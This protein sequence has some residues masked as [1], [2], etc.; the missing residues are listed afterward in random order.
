MR[1]E[2]T[3]EFVTTLR[4]IGALLVVIGHYFNVFWMKRDVVANLINAPVLSYEIYPLPFYIDWLQKLN[5]LN[6][7]GWRV[8]LFFIISGFVIPFSLQKYT[9]T[10]FLVNRFIR[11]VPTYAIGFSLTLGM[12]WWGTYYFSTSWPYST[13]EILIHYLPGIRELADSKSIDGIIWTLEIEIKFYVLCALFIRWF[14]TYSIKIFCI[15]ILL[16]LFTL[17]VDYKPNF[18]AAIHS[19][20]YQLAMAY[21]RST[22]FI[23]FMFIG[24]LLNYLYNKKI[25][26]KNTYLG[27][28]ALFTLFCFEW[29]FGPFNA[30]FGEIKNYVF[31]LFVFILAYH[32]PSL[33]KANKF[34]TFLAN[35]SY[36]L[37]IIHG[38]CGYILL[39]ILLDLGCNSLISLAVTVSLA[40]LSAWVIH[41]YVERPMKKLKIENAVNWSYRR[42][43]AQLGMSLLERK[44]SIK[45]SS[46]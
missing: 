5:I 38:V 41:L 39:R 19:P 27:I 4:G 33:F 37:Y 45:E 44:S 35:I 12:L 18:W 6:L 31:A 17:W 26:V 28:I 14:R 46:L 13:Q 32:V 9:S 22:Q 2:D 43:F 20:F 36:P 11:I 1:K 3:K 15:P 25:N 42:F 29:W 24:V 16:F 34:F 7:G 10:Q 8:P 23:I 30:I 21:F 40:L